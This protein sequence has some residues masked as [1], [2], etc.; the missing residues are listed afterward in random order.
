MS[1][2]IDRN[3]A[4][5]YAAPAGKYKDGR[6]N[7]TAWTNQDGVPLVQYAKVDEKPH[8]PLPMD[9]FFLYDGYLSKFSR[10]EDGTLY[11]MG[12]AVK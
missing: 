7:I 8:T 4:G 6:Y 3:K 10:G 1:Y 2:W 5:A 9:N 12:K 11:Y